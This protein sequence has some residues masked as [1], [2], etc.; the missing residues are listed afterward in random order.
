MT[1]DGGRGTLSSAMK[2]LLIKWDIVEPYWQDAMRHQFVKE[3]LTPVR[4]QTARLMGA[5][6]QMQVLL[7]QMQRDCEGISYDIHEGT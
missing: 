7:T 1:L 5:I 3:V 6:D 4:D 2:T